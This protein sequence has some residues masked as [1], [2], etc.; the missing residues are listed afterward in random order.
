MDVKLINVNKQDV[1]RFE[2]TAL[3]TNLKKRFSNRPQKWAM[4]EIAAH[5]I[6]WIFLLA[7]VNVTWASDWFDKSIRPESLA[8][9]TI[10]L[11]PFMCYLHGMILIPR[12]L[13]QRRWLTY[14]GFCVLLF[15][16]PELIRS[17]S[18][19]LAFQNHTFW[20]EFTGRDSLILGILNPAVL[21]FQF[22]FFYKITKDWFLQFIIQNVKEEQLPNREKTLS[23]ER[24]EELTTLKVEKIQP[25][26]PEEAAI[27]K[28]DLQH[29]MIAEKPYLNPT[30]KLRDLAKGVQTTE[31]KLSYF[32]NHYQ[33]V[34]FYDYVNQ[35]RVKAFVVKVRTE[36]VAHLSLTGVA[37][38]CGFKSKS[39]FYRAFKQSMGISPAAYIK[40]NSVKTSAFASNDTPLRS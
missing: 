31:K 15:V 21:A 16:I 32:L 36:E 2:N 19:S 34:K 25:L 27:L 3:L 4:A 38:E 40:Q 13:K 17:M 35:F 12:F 20:G 5:V 7:A 22:S 37:L 18:L 6:L 26:K 28:E 29:I 11:F 1:N 14:I 33:K 9:L 10:L 8:P 39:S 24:F 23:K 30:I